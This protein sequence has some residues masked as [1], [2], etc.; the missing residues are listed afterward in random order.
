ML[1]GRDETVIQTDNIQSFAEHLPL[2][3]FDFIVLSILEDDVTEHQLL[4]E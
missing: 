3:H 2:S 4:L 1:P